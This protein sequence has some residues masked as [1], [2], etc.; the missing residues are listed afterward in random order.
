M[1]Y[2]DKNSI[3]GRMKQCYENVFKYKLPERMPVII[4]LDGRAFH[5]LTKKAEKPFDSAFIRFIDETALY[6]CE[7]IDGVQMAYIQSDEIS[8]LL[9]NYK[10][11]NTNSWF[12]NEIQKICSISAGLASSKF[13]LIYNSYNDD[14]IYVNPKLIQFDSRC[15]VLPEAEVCNY[16]IWRQK[17]WERNS[18]QMLAQSLYSHKQLHKKNNSELQEMC[19][20]K[21][22]NWNDLD[23]SLRRG[24]CCIKEFNEDFN[25]DDA[26]YMYSGRYN[27]VI[28]NE[29]P[30]FTQDRNYIEKYLKVE[31]E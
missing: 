31:E 6:L 5:T 30:I 19:F 10:K 16:F 26:S 15:F 14:K 22:H 23:I 28:D 24:R 25:E 27:W 21:G 1:K 20:Q 2:D 7:E 8:L 17:D 29:I 13:T 12:D 18:I 11:L 3:G 4:R 9:H